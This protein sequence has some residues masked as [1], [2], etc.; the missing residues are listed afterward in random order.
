[1]N[2][3][4]IHIDAQ[5][6]VRHD[7]EANWAAVDPVLRDGEVAYSKDLNRIK[8][9]DGARKWSD[10]KYLGGT[11]GDAATPR[12][13]FFDVAE[14]LAFAGP[15]NRQTREQL[16]NIFSYTEGG[17][18]PSEPAWVIDSNG[19][20]YI[21][22]ML[23]TE[24]GVG[25]FIIGY[26]GFTRIEGDN[27]K[28]NQL[29]RDKI[30]KEY[31]KDFL[32][33]ASFDPA[34]THDYIIP[35]VE[36]YTSVEDSVGAGGRSVNFSIDL[37]IKDDIAS[38]AEDDPDNGLFRN[39][40]VTALGVK[41][42]VENKG[43]LTSAAMGSYATKAD[44][45]NF[46]TKGTTLAHYGITDAVKD[47]S[48]SITPNSSSPSVGYALTSN[49][50]AHQGAVMK[51]GYMGAYQLRL[52][53]KSGNNYI[54]D[55]Y[56][57]GRYLNNES[58]WAKVL[59]DNNIGSLA[60]A[61][62]NDGRN[63]LATDTSAKCGYVYGEN[64]W[65]T[66]G[67]ALITNRGGYSGLFNFAMSNMGSTPDNITLYINLNSGGTLGNW[68][69][70]VTD[71]NFTEF[72]VKAGV[73]ETT[74]S[75]NDIVEPSIVG[76]T[77]N[78][79]NT[80]FN[81]GN[82]LTMTT[83]TKY[84]VGQIVINYAGRMSVRGRSESAW[85]E[86]AEVL[87][88]KNIG[89]YADSRY[90]K[91]T[92]GTLS[93]QLYI[94]S[95][96][97]DRYIHSKCNTA[98][99]AFGVGSGGYN[100]GIFDITNGAWWIYRNSANLAFFAGDS[101]FEGDVTLAYGKGLTLSDVKITK[102]SDIAPYIG[103]G[104][105]KNNT[106]LLPNNVFD[107]LGKI[108]IS[109]LDNA[110][111]AAAHRFN[112]TLDG[113]ASESKGVLFNGSYEDS[114]Q[115]PMGQTATIKIDNNGN[116]IIAG[117]PYGNIILSFYYQSVP[118][119][120]SIRVYTTYGTAG[121]YSLPL[122]EIR[123]T[124]GGVFVFSNGNYAVKEVEI[125]ITAKANINAAL[126]EIDW[127]LN[128]ASLSNLP[129]VTKFGIDQEL[130]GRLICKGGLTLDNKTV[131]SWSDFITSDGGTIN[132]GK[133]LKFA[134]SAYPVSLGVAAT[135]DGYD[136]LVVS[137]LTQMSDLYITEKLYF[138]KGCTVTFRNW[139][140]GEKET[141]SS[142]S[143]LKGVLGLGSLAYKDDTDVVK[144]NYTIAESAFNEMGYGYKGEVW[145]YTAPA[146]S[147]GANNLYYSQIQIFS[148][149]FC[150]RSIRNGV[151]TDWFTLLKTTGNLK[152]DSEA[153]T[154]F[155]QL[156]LHRNGENTD[157]FLNYGARSY[158]ISAYGSFFRFFCN[159]GTVRAFGVDNEGLFTFDKG[160]CLGGKT[161][162]QW[163]DLS[164][165]LSY[166]Q[167]SD[168]LMPTN[169]FDTAGQ[170]AI[171]YL[172]NAIYAGS[173]RF[174]INNAGGWKRFKA[175]A[176]FDGSYDGDFNVVSAGESASITISNNG[177]NI[178][179]GFP[180]GTIF[181]SFYYTYIPESATV[182]VYCNYDA[183]GIGWKTLPR[184][185][186]RGNLNGVWGYKNDYYDITKVRITITASSLTD[187]FLQEIDWFLTRGSL[188]NLP[189]VTKFG[190]DQELWGRLICKGGITLGG[191]TIN[192]W[193]EVRSN[194]GW[195]YTSLINQVGTIQIDIKIRQKTTIAETLTSAHRLVFNLIT[196]ANTNP[197]WLIVFTTGTTVPIIGI[198]KGSDSLYWQNNQNILNNL[199]PHTTYR[200]YIDSN[201]VMYDT[202]N[203]L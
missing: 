100:R 84:Y 160:I 113:F 174:T 194:W 183:Q 30:D 4:A 9:G 104:F 98:H 203:V 142:F 176:L 130:Y 110:L 16:Y 94:E 198:A 138:E 81:Y 40:L 52:I 32:S 61:M 185:I 147:F 181:L 86:W 28:T 192:S 105:V 132:A 167:K 18:I 154:S 20:H 92:G 74:G 6:Q 149:V 159:N 97:G 131:F 62:D 19:Q 108:Q 17:E 73:K 27:T 21:V 43:Y 58:E 143:D 57:S 191:E 60:I 106:Q 75:A 115:V 82:L 124:N 66:T 55:I 169:N 31:V 23:Q 168:M 85:T 109:Q 56:I 171:N 54:P 197:E 180:Y 70:V 103:G 71:K 134:T 150:Y 41:N 139:S 87:T 177:S 179:S 155:G 44:I 26:E 78:L 145:Q 5:I 165:V 89:D 199:S 79:S 48:Y 91:L 117:C 3:A 33:Q 24:T 201:L 76:Y 45:A 126:S 116:D 196:E 175:S 189:V 59:T 125:T 93:G 166:L 64:G 184:T 158:G 39:G 137:G 13:L 172:N 136:K 122:S 77:E 156:I 186:V 50:W 51:L 8:V 72:G 193:A 49:G 96:S 141:I 2:E 170:L 120:V 151:A 121:W 12:Q 1:M 36:S 162:N 119:S 133:Y 35:K 67:P 101:R 63:L 42:W 129:V 22:K 157:T 34:K 127:F 188:S 53:A 140:T 95:T 14:I 164:S 29:L 128:S 182:E 153:F 135:L 187:A 88:N 37:R 152:I 200:I 69:K 123:G 102:W 163:S 15:I 10:L 148:D 195:R 146:I 99:I 11:N 46:V 202:F 83:K 38:A 173:E 68:A 90:L 161:I 80:P 65:K 190:I 47:E 114:I 111:Y 107:N 144:W 25:F 7:I 118:E 178:I 112:I